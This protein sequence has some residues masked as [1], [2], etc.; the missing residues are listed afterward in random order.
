MQT[1]LLGLDML[2]AILALGG[3]VRCCEDPFVAWLGPLRSAR[4]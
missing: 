3:D 2:I 4:S 1:Y